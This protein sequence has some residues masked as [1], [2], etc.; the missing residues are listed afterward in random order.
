MDKLRHLTPTAE[1]FCNVNQA[2]DI[3]Y[4]QKSQSWLVWQQVY[5]YVN[6][7]FLYSEISR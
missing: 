5:M 3:L 7:C 1:Q 4:Q 2:Y 6:F